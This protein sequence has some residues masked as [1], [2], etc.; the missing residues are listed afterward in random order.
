MRRTCPGEAT[1]LR[2]LW[3][4]RNLLLQ[5]IQSHAKCFETVVL[6]RAISICGIQC[7]CRQL[8]CPAGLRSMGVSCAA[9][10]DF[11]EVTRRTLFGGARSLRTDS[12]GAQ[13]SASRCHNEGQ[14]GHNPAN[15]RQ[16]TFRSSWCCE[17]HHLFHATLPYP[18]SQPPW[19]KSCLSRA[20]S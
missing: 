8:G 11:H 12:R 15:L 9:T 19:R 7:G 2:L 1:I 4:G 16:Q 3:D 20:T 10:S 13:G 14:H 18:P 17:T 5:I 6:Q